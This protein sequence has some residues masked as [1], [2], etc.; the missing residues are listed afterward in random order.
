MSRTSIE[1]CARPGKL[2]EVWNV[3]TGCNKVSQGCKNCY[4]EIMHKRLQFMY[5]EKYDHDFLSGAH[6]HEDLLTLP[7]TWKKPRTVFVNSMSDLFHA[8]V[9]ISFL[10]K[11]YAIMALCP[12]HTFIIVTKRPENSK[13][14][15][16]IG[17][18]KLVSC[19]ENATYEMGLSDKDEDTDAPACALYNYTEKNWPLPNVWHLVSTEDQTTFRERVNLLLQIP[20]RVYGISA[21][22]LLGPIDLEEYVLLR[23]DG[24]YPFRNLAE[25]H[26]T[27]YI[28]LLDWIVCGGESGHHGRP[29]HPDWPR[30][31]K[32][33]CVKAKKP[34][35]FKQWGEYLPYIKSEMKP[36][37][38]IVWIGRE[39]AELADDSKSFNYPYD[40]HE[41]M[42]KVGKK[43]AGRLLDG[44]EW[45]QFPK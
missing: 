9:P 30:S 38:K 21:E 3:V 28:D 41:M 37:Q 33:T 32:N 16:D 8:N 1:W 22:P 4:A 20:S 36:F 7:F 43:K 27:K 24:T 45:N 13:A 18:E 17:K 40:F 2:P 6:I 11:V 14:Y 31:M 39:T 5:P 23:K 35:F 34:F 25:K 15:F 19:W 10:H 26:R 12:K 44:K 42:A 29:M